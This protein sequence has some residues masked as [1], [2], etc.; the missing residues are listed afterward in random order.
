MA[1]SVDPAVK[2]ELRR[3]MRMVRDLVDDHTL[4][5]VQ[6]WA[7][8]ADLPEYRAA[9]T[10]MAFV[11]MKGEPDTDPLVARLAAEGRRLLLPRVEGDRIVAVD[12]D[13][14]MVTSRFGVREPQG[15]AVDESLIDLV[16]VPGLAF[17][18]AGAR[19][20]YGGGFY[21]RFLP[22]VSAPHVGVCFAEQVLDDLPVEPHDIRVQHVVSA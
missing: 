18:P 5:S 14:P 12:A 10:V 7:L 16:V 9:R 2:A 15:P 13:G 3:R 1:N 8:L 20:G 21:D 11:G 17:T 4:R 19:L 22:L 6:L